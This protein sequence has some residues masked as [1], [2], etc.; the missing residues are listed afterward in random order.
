MWFVR[1]SVEPIDPVKDWTGRREPYH[2]E[3]LTRFQHFVALFERA[4]R[5][6]QVVCQLS[7]TLETRES[8]SSGGKCSLFGTE[9][10]YRRYRLVHQFRFIPAAKC[11]RILRHQLG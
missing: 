11:P 3:V 6:V 10:P 1:L 4:V 7:A 5:K 2:S 8:R 9:T